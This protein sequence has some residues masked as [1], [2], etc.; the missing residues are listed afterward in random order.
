M[1]DHPPSLLN[2]E[3]LEALVHAW[4]EQP[5]TKEVDTFFVTRLA[6]NVVA[7]LAFAVWLLFG[8]WWTTG[9]WPKAW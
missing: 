5:Q 3:E 2:A 7:M 8:C 9:R 1:K 4:G 6:F